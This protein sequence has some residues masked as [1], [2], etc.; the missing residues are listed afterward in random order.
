MKEFFQQPQLIWFLI[1]LILMLL[2]L[3]IPGLVLIFFGIGAWVAALACLLFDPG[4]NTQLLIF[5]ASSIVSLALLRRM[6]RNRYMDRNEPLGGNLEDEYIGQTAVAV[7]SFNAGE[8]GKVSFKGTNW[9][10]VATQPVTEG[11]QLRITGY[12]SIRLFVEPL[13]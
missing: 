1:G 10:A 6:L 9:E 8:T 4:L 5:L 12:K 2:E 3:V 13:Q 7:T 11:Q